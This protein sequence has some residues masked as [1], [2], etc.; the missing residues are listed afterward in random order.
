[1]YRLGGKEVPIYHPC[2]VPC[3]LLRISFFFSRFAIHILIKLFSHLLRWEKMQN[4]VSYW[5]LSNRFLSFDCKAKKTDTITEDTIAHSELQLD[6]CL[7][8]LCD[9]SAPR[10]LPWTCSN[11]AWYWVERQKCI[12]SIPVSH[13][14]SFYKYIP[15]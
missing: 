1:M 3:C 10:G 15:R 2:T 4:P 6:Q 9:S 7:V 8:F 13:I 11:I 14:I 12:G 5:D